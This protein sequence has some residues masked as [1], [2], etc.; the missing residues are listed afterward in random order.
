MIQNALPCC[1]GTG[2]TTVTS[3]ILMQGTVCDAAQLASVV[4]TM[5]NPQTLVVVECDFCASTYTAPNGD[6]VS[7]QCFTQGQELYWTETGWIAS[8]GDKVLDGTNI[9]TCPNSVSV[10]HQLNPLGVLEFNKIYSSD[11][12]ILLSQSAGCI[13]IKMGAIAS[14][15]ICSLFPIVT[16]C[17]T[18]G[19]CIVTSVDNE[20][21]SCLLPYLRDKLKM[22]ELIQ[23]IIIPSIND[24]TPSYVSV[25][26]SAYVNSHFLQAVSGTGGI[27]C[28]SPSGQLSH[29]SIPCNTF[30]TVLGAFSCL[31]PMISGGTIANGSVLSWNSTSSCFE[32]VILSGGGGGSSYS[33]SSNTYNIPSG[34]ELNFTGCPGVIIG[35]TSSGG[36]TN[37]SICVDPGVLSDRNKKQ[38]IGD[39]TVNALDVINKLSPAT[40]EYLDEVDYDLTYNGD[41]KV[42]AGFIA[43]DVEAI[44]PFAVKK[45]IG[46]DNK[47]IELQALVALQTK[48]IQELYTLITKK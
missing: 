3:G 21:N 2:G 42:H 23:D 10:F 15:S 9:G 44:Y 16:G 7:G 46:G 19:G 25:F 32:P 47:V 38:N 39:L 45:E 28:L 41:K 43:Q 24:I 26:S 48:A 31:S 35:T 22:S 37:V 20:V 33:F 29:T 6:I 8:G 1:G 13:D 11:N 18:P 34:G 4:P 12:S 5:I 40:F 14:P 27:A 36:V 17:G 30:S